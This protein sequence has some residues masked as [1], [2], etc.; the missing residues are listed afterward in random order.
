[1]CSHFC[2]AQTSVCTSKPKA[3]GQGYV[4]LFLLNNIGDVITIEFIRRV[5]R[6]VKVNC[7]G[8]DVL[9]THQVLSV[10]QVLKL[11]NE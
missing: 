1:M 11:V 4:D 5:A 10:P 8:E 7:W 6:M 2:K 9:Q 3:I